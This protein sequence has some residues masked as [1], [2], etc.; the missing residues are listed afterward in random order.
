LGGQGNRD[1]RLHA[2]YAYNFGLN[3]NVDGTALGKG[4]YLTVGLTWRIDVMQAVTKLVDKV[5]NKR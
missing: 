5:S 1:V 4:S 2:A 3:T